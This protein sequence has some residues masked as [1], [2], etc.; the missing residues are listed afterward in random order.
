[1][2][3]A[4]SNHGDGDTAASLPHG[5][6]GAKEAWRDN[7]GAIAVAGYRAAACDF[8]RYA[9]SLWIDPYILAAVAQATLEIIESVGAA[10]NV[11]LGHSM[12]GMVAQE[13]CAIACEGVHGADPVCQLGSVW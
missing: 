9:A 8:P 4:H 6:S 13:V 5:V 11:L 1:M 7:I 10:R 2:I 12:G 3:L